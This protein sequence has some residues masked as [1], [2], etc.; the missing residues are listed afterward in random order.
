MKHANEDAKAHARDKDRELLRL[1]REE[2]DP[3]ALEHLVQRHLPLVRSLARRYAGR[4]EPLEDI[5]QVGAIGLLKAINRFEVERE[6]SLATYAT[7]NVVGEIKRH[8]RD[9]GW[10]IR[11]PRSLQELNAKMS[12]TI[13]RLTSQLGHSPSV[14]ELAAALETTPEEVLEA[15]EVGSA[16]TTLSLS[17]SPAGE[18]GTSDPMD[19]IGEED[20]GFE[21]SEDRVSLAPALGT[22]APRERDI[23]RMRFEE[24]L[25]QTQIADRVGLSQMHVSRL[26]RK[27]L[28]VMRAE[29]Q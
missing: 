8:F 17:A 1:H 25:P 7:P 26:I 14:G 6:V 10:A 15:M 18:D 27:S 3:E 23:L 5:E 13:D 11:V 21:Q 9:K 19:A 12:S 2:G 16:Y 20:L 22:L 29:L 4:G 24:G 28:A